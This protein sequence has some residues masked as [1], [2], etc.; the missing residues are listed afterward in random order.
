MNT[1]IFFGAG[2]LGKRMLDLWQLFGIQPDFF[3]DNSKKS[4]N[5]FYYGIRVLGAEELKFMKDFQILI[6]CNQIDAIRNQ[7]LGLGINQNNIFKGNTLYDM[8]IFWTLY[9]KEKLHWNILQKTSKNMDSSC[10]YSVIFDVQYG[11][12][13]GGVET[14]VLHTANE[15]PF[16]KKSVKFISTD[17][18]NSSTYNLN[19]RE[20]VLNDWNN[21]SVK[22]KLEQCLT[23]IRESLP[24]NIVCNFPTFIFWS[25]CIAKILWPQEVNLIAVIHNDVD[26]YYDQYSEMQSSIDWCLTIST[27]IKNSLLEKGFPIEKIRDLN[28]KISFSNKLERS[29]SKKG[30]I[31]RL[32]YAGRVT[33]EQKRVDLLITIS[34]RLKDLG[35]DFTLEIA[36]IGDYLQTI[37]ELVKKYELENQVKLLGLISNDKVNEFWKCKDIAVSCSEFEGRSI[38]QAEAMAAGTVLVITDTSGARDYVE[39]GYNGYIVP[40]GD[41][42][43][44]VNRIYYLYH[45]RELVEIMGKRSY[46]AIIRQNEE[47]NIEA[48]WNKIL[49]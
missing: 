47:N 1:I 40:I 32:G 6:T 34:E 42:E 49:K 28:W 8:L 29:Y 36:G 15:L 16:Q 9:M 19:D 14:W 10:F 31:L 48:M 11:F 12:I 26:I 21:L 39:D 2:K 23:I 46:E 30:N 24:C 44:M 4:N 5:T 41:V 7:L 3:V 18:M 38:S 27:K 35:V 25:A 20:I 13:L 43:A 33:L 37:R 45:H 17:I 22:E